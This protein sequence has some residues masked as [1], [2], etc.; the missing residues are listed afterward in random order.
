MIHRAVFG[1]LE[2][3]IGLL[4]EHFSGDFPLWLAPEQIRIIPITD[5]Q[6]EAADAL[7]ARCKSLRLRATIDDSSH[8]MGAKIRRAQL[9]KAPLMV[10]LGKREIEND[11][12]AVRSRAKGDEGAVDTEVFLQ[13]VAAEIA[14]RG[15]HS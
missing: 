13:Q 5:A 4:I 11:Q 7:L 2:R 12:V 9:E 10:I 8:K 6:I 3:F 1:S 15:E 14:K